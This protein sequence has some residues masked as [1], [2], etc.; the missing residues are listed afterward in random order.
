MAEWET[1]SL[2]L[3]EVYVEALDRLVELG[4]F[5]SR[6]HAIREAIR[7]LIESHRGIARIIL[8][9]GEGLKVRAP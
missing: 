5:K 1:V 2:H 8:G 6:S 9:E 3:P 4:V 7:R